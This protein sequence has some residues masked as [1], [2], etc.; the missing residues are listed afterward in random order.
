[1][2][3]YPKYEISA[4]RLTGIADQAR[5]LGKV[6][7]KLTPGQIQETL[8]GVGSLS[9]AEETTFGYVKKTETVTEQAPEGKCWYNGVLLPEIPA[10]DGYSVSFIRKNISAGLYYAVFAKEQVYF[11][12]N[13]LKGAVSG[14]SYEA[15]WYTLPTTDGDSWTY[16]QT[17]NTWFGLD[18][19]RVL[20]WSNHDIPNGSATATAIYFKGSE[21]LTELTETIKKHVP[22]ERESNYSI[23]SESLN[24][25]AKR[26]QE[27]AG[28]SKLFTPDDIIYW[29]GR[30]M[31]IPQ[32]RS[33][34]EFSLVPLVFESAA[35]AR[36]PEVVK[37]AANSEFSLASLAFES[38]A[39]GALSE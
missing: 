8:T 36:L 32:G 21:P 17:S 39:V 15:T 25:I 27:M 13:G 38:S 19:D 7:G 9:N 10:V 28:T 24:N 20:L 2:A 14:T 33:I 1:M 16:A 6:S 18:D 31:F 11:L 34:S 4:Q 23:T 12:D 26:T 35:S 29:L 30:V 3:Q 5:R 22:V 37:A